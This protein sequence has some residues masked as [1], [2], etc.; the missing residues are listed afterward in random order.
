MTDF[1]SCAEYSRYPIFQFSRITVRQYEE[2]Q[3]G[4]KS[5][6]LALIT[7][8]AWRVSYD[9]PHECDCEHC[10]RE[11]DRNFMMFTA[12]DDARKFILRQKP[13]NPLIEEDWY[14][15]KAVKQVRTGLPIL[16]M[17]AS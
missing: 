3:T 12:E 2:I 13:I 17:V 8:K 6:E 11:I 1:I 5:G 15:I 10:T 16:D 4:V 7:G 9:E 14:Y